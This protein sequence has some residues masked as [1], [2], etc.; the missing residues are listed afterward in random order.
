MKTLK[1][2]FQEVVLNFTKEHSDEIRDT[3][4]YLGFRDY[5]DMLEKIQNDFNVAVW[6]FTEL[7]SWGLKRN[8]RNELFTASLPEN[9][10]SDP[11]VYK[12]T[13]LTGETIYFRLES[14]D[15]WNLNY[16]IV[17]MTEITEYVKVTK[18]IDK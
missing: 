16:E 9:F 17:E 11:I 18:W 8:Y 6:A 4:D 2:K 3:W 7:F 1:E 14:F 15:T 5:G 10:D 13:D 12:I